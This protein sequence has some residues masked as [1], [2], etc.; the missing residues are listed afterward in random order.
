M[1]KLFVLLST[2]NYPVSKV[3]CLFI[4]SSISKKYWTD[5]LMKPSYII[6][7]P[8]YIFIPFCHTLPLQEVILPA[9]RVHPAYFI[10][11]GE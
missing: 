8:G 7:L 2:E 9:L 5:F 10:Y 4:P 6:P 3:L 11:F 1:L